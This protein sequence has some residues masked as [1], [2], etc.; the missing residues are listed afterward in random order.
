MFGNMTT[1]RRPHLIARP[2]VLFLL[3]SLLAV[4]AYVN[5]FSGPFHFDDKDYIVES[6]L[7]KQLDNFLNPSLFLYGSRTV[8]FLT[9]SLN[10]RFGGLSVFGFHLVNLLIHLINGGLVYLLVCL[11]FQTPRITTGYPSAPS[12]SP[13]APPSAP[14]L[15]LT[16]A[17]LFLVHPVQTQAVTYITQRFTSL[18]ALFSLLTVI[19]YL[20]WRL[21]APADRRR[22]IWYGGALLATILAM[23]TKENTFTLPFML[24]LVEVVFFGLPTRRG[25]LGLLPF[26]FILPIIPLAGFARGSEAGLTRGTLDISRWNYL[27]TQF[28]VIVTY[29]R[30]LVLPINQNLDY[31]YPIFHSLFQPPVFLSFLGLLGLGGWALWLLLRKPAPSTTARLMAFGV[32][33]FF[34]T[35]SIESSVIPIR[36]VINEYRLYLPSVGLFLAASA[37][38][39]GAPARRRVGAAVAVGLV[40]IV[41]S[42]ATYERNQVWQ[43][44]RSL[45]Q[46]VIRKSPN[47]ARGYYSLG[48]AYKEQG[49]WSEA[50]TNYKKALT[51]DPTDSRIHYDLANADKA[52]GRISESINEYHAAITLDPKFAEA[53]NNLG[54]VFEE[55]G[56]LDGA[57]RE[58]Q[59]AIKYKPYLADAHNN[60]G[61]T[62]QKRGRPENAMREY[63]IAITLDPGFAEA[64]HNLGIMYKNAGR[65]Q[66][67]A[68]NYEHAVAL[69]PNN[70]DLHY[71]LGGIYRDLGRLE[72]AIQHYQATIQLKP[73]FPDAYNN[74]GFVYYLQKKFPAS[75]SAFEKGIELNPNDAQAHNALGLVYLNLGRVAEAVNEY[76][77]AIRLKPDY[78]GAYMNL[79]MVLLNQGKTSDALGA[80]DTALQLN[81]N[82]PITHNLMGITLERLGR[83]DDAIRHFQTAV[84]LKPD[85][86][87][88]YFHLGE[89]YQQTGHIP[90]AITAFKK[91]LQ[92]HPN[93]E[94][95]RRAL[96]ALGQ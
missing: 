39:F 83:S 35:L 5:S 47:K 33:W 26:F 25:W 96:A 90:Q 93:D 56:D 16:T 80:F 31:D 64:Y 38:L 42:I 34:L 45:W 10:Y 20:Q 92:M 48:V 84:K 21:S 94:N 8:G 22:W 66:E 30:L 24:L 78:A 52:L 69:N 77:T 89:L 91:V 36:D 15:A 43:S 32:L 59:T 53:H 87:E 17:A 61:I 76:Q 70:P 1:P 7:I 88:A 14:W 74:L 71:Y 13:A 81:P 62:F 41:L 3:L 60:L 75:L 11:L 37:L 86:A 82:T 95:V 67:A 72:E 23:K 40:V 85:F 65:L 29:L 46:D 57:I 12:A 28:R 44:E 6:P 79:G 4:A 68:Q 63:Q 2:C 50:M 58:Y 27:L 55:Q 51:L 18:A 49:K 9:F 73:D 19:C 54:I